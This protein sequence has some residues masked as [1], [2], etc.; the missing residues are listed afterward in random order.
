MKMTNAIALQNAIDTLSTVEQTET[1]TATIERLTH[2]H[3]TL[4]ERAKAIAS[5]EKVKAANEKRKAETKAARDALMAT[6]LPVIR[7][8]ITTE[9]KTA[10]Q[11]YE[12]CK[13]NLPADFTAKKVQYILIHELAG[14]VVKVDN[15]RNS[16]TYKKA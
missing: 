11:I 5:S 12:D 6:V 16:K 1:I 8:V 7:S 2:M 3:E 14:E 13:V 9:D 10:E 4:V 15:G